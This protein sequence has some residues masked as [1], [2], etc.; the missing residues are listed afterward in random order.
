MSHL[1]THENVDMRLFEGHEGLKQKHVNGCGE[2]RAWTAHKDSFP[3]GPIFRQS[4]KDRL[5]PRWTLES[6]TTSLFRKTLKRPCNG[7]LFDS[8][9]QM[10]LLINKGDEGA[11]RFSGF[12]PKLTSRLRLDHCVATCP[13]GRLRSANPCIHP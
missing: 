2:F 7:N 1:E 11:I 9:E 8:E 3:E 12:S 13:P 4:I 10:S 5:P 6:K